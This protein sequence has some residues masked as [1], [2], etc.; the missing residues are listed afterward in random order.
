MAQGQANGDFTYA[1]REGGGG[2]TLRVHLAAGKD[3]ALS[4]SAM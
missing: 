3:W 4:S 2:Y 1:L